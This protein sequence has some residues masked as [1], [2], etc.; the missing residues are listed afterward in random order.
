MPT[1]STS[2]ATIAA[3]VRQAYDR[4]LLIQ[5][6]P[7]LVHCQFGSKKPIPKGQGNIINMRRVELLSPATTPLTE[8][9]T[10]NGSALTVSNVPITVQ[11]YGDYVALTDKVT[12]Q[13][14]DPLV[15]ET[16]SVQAQQAANTLDQLARD[17]FVT[18]ASVRYAGGQLS[19]SAVTSANIM[20]GLEIKRAVRTLKKNNAQ[21]ING[22]YVCIVSPDTSMDIQG[23]SEWLAVKEYSDRKDLY[24]GEL[25]MLYGVRFVETTNAKIFVGQ[26][27]GGIDV[28]CSLFFGQDAF[29]TSEIDGEA[30]Q[31]ISSPLGSGGSSDP[32]AQ[33]QT[34]AW[35]ATWGSTILNDYF[36]TR[37][38]HAVSA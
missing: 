14:I 20:T 37:V 5:A 10:P 9:V 4:A 31:T 24:N 28:H 30:L 26:G 33:R 34:Q 27:S 25:G 18:G 3:E 22:S 17:T 38:E 2:T 21:R 19:R 29:G 35:K 36:V 23:I 11:Q 15:I 32:L 12:W 8:G 16:I 13:S 7:E 1:V 6:R